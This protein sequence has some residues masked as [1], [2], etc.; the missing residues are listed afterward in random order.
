M[1]QDDLEDL[2]DCTLEIS[3][4]MASISDKYPLDTF[5]MALDFLLTNEN[6]EF[7]L[8]SHEKKEV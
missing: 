6:L 5:R 4:F 7:Y 8:Y 1:I 3:H 2:T